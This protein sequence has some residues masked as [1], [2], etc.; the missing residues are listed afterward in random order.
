VT[1]CRHL[2]SIYEQLTGNLG[3]AYLSWTEEKV[4]CF[5]DGVV[6]HVRYEPFIFRTNCAIRQALLGARSRTVSGGLLQGKAP[7]SCGGGLS[8]NVPN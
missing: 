6:L 2:G 3:D 7:Y 5:V 1:S 8:A 4:E